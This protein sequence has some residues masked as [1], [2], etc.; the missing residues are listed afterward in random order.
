MKG[1]PQHYLVLGLD[2]RASGAE[3]RAAYVRLVKAHY[4]DGRGGGPMERRIE[5]LQQAYHCLREPARRAEYDEL[6][7]RL[8]R[9]HSSQMVR[10]Q[11]RLRHADRPRPARRRS[12]AKRRA[13][14]LTLL[15]AGAFVAARA[16]LP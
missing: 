16:L 10:V 15:S 2:R 12:T 3:V 4:A 8:E 1:A 11:R 6:L 7:D 13:L 14:L 9:E 5:Y